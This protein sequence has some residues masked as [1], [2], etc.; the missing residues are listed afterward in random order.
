M[1][2]LN[3]PDHIVSLATSS[4]LVSVDVNVWTATKQDR[5]ISNEVT[6]S[7]KADEGAGKFVKYLFAN[8]EQH[9][10]IAKT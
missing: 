8:N 6:T 9:K 7:K 1:T 4:L 5:G 2:E 10:K 3:Q